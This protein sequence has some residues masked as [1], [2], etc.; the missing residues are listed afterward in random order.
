MIN[1]TENNLNSKDRILGAAE[2]LFAEKGFDGVSVRDIAEQAQANVAM[3]N[4]YFRNKEDL[5]LGI[6]ENY[7]AE[8]NAELDKV[9]SSAADPLLRLELFVNCYSDFLFQKAISAQLILR[10]GLQNDHHI[11]L[12]A[13]KYFSQVIMKGEQ[14]IQDGIRAGYFRPMDT[15][16]A[17][18]SL[19]GQMVY[20]FAAAP[21]I[22]R[23]SGMEDYQQKYRQH[24]AQHTR[25]LFVDGISDRGEAGNG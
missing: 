13:R 25:S 3:I 20:F 19:L 12:L 18:I 21:V 1:L 15:K 23:I 24:L 6:L 2:Q 16:L 9:L 10:A 5:Y 14:I 4:Y 22:S 11:D 8:F 7:L 17:T